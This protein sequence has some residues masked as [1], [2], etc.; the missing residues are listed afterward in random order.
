MKNCPQ[1]QA[2]YADDFQVCTADGT[3]LVQ[4]ES[5]PN[6]TVI[7]GKYRIL[8]RIG[9]DAVCAAYQA[10][11]L[12]TNQFRALRVMSWG[13]AI[14]PSF[15]KLF[16]QDAHQR[17]KLRHPNVSHVEDTG[18]ADDKRPFIVMEYVAGQSLKKFIEQD[19][20]FT[21]RR[22]CAI[23]RQVAA[24]LEAAHALGMVH[25]DIK[26]EIIYV[27]DGP[28]EERIKVLGFGTTK[29]QEALLGDSFR[30]SPE[31]MIGT[32]EY[33]SPEQALG[34]LGSDLDGRV[35]IYSLGV[36]LYQMITGHLP[37]NAVTAADW[38]MAHIQG[39]PTPIRVAYADLAIPDVL[40]DLVIQCLKKNREQRPASARQ[41]V[42]DLENVEKEIERLEAERTGVPESIGR[43]SSGWKFWKR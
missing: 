8:S 3:A 34:Q 32:L 9:Q 27:L 2:T 6:G 25:R 40:I 17:K 18:V 15:V 19:A 13:L 24:G 10:L 16:E 28:G 37:F 42:R 36:V 7:Q 14:D 41:L 31:A 30:T 26:P 43:R 23:A 38:M 20:P 22:A 33:L 39:V 12:K 29:L 35:D 1:C 11:H 4:L 21:P 5:W